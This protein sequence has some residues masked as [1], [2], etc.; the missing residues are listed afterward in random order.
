[1]GD[2][3]IDLNPAYVKAQTQ[4]RVTAKLRKKVELALSVVN[5]EN[6][7]RGARVP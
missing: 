5:G 6:G 4:S 3:K 7:H 1:M 2:L